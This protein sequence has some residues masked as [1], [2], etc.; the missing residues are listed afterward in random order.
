M[1]TNEEIII[2]KIAD[3]I[4]RREFRKEQEIADQKRRRNTLIIDLVLGVITIIGGSGLLYLEFILNAPI[5]ALV[6]IAVFFGVVSGVIIL[7]IFIESLG[8]LKSE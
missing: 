3:E 1:T 2:K 4:E 7:Y 8:L 5:L 6:I